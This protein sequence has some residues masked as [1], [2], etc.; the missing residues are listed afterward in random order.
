[1]PKL[2][3]YNYL[4][5]HILPT[6]YPTRMACDVYNRQSLMPTDPLIRKT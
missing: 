1:M 6:L 3:A 4:S 2:Q 5:L